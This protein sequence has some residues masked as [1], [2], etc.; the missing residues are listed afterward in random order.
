ML[1]QRRFFLVSPYPGF[2]TR[3]TTV[4]F[5]RRLASFT[6]MN[7]PLFASRPRG[8]VLDLAMA[9]ISNNVVPMELFRQREPDLELWQCICDCIT[10][11]LLSDGSIRC[12][13]CGQVSGEMRCF[14][15]SDL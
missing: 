14:H 15:T 7:F 1:G 3:S 8:V 5:G 6:G 13:S 10:F 4:V 12:A 9:K 2:G 11:K